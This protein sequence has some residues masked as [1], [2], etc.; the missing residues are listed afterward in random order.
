MIHIRLYCDGE[1]VRRIR[2]RGHGHGTLGERACHGVSA[3]SRTLLHVLGINDRYPKELTYGD[4]DMVLDGR[5]RSQ[6]AAKHTIIGYRL[7]ASVA[8]DHVRIRRVEESH[9]HEGG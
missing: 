5:R 3:L 6:E 2:V 7:I 9:E 1:V 8:P 4:F